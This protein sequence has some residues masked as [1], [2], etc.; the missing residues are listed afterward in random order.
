MHRSLIFSS[1]FV[2]FQIACAEGNP[3]TNFNCGDGVIQE[4]EECEPPNQG[5]CGEYC[6]RDTSK[7]GDGLCESPET[8]AN[9]A[10]DCENSSNCGNG[11]RDMGED[12]DGTD[13]NEAT[14]ES[15]G[16]GAG[17]LTC[18]NTCKFDISGC[19]SPEYC[20]N[21]IVDGTEECDTMDLNDNDC[22]TLGYS[23][24]TLRC[25][26]SCTYNTEE[27]IDA[28]CGNNTA[29]GSED[30]DGT[31]LN[32]GTCSTAGT[33]NNGAL[34]CNN[35]CTY[36]DS[37]CG[38]CPNNILEGDEEC[39]GTDLGT[40][41]CQSVGFTGGSLSCNANCTL[42]T[43]S[44]TSCGNGTIEGTEECDQS[45]LGGATCASLGYQGGT[46][47]CGATCTFNES[48]CYNVVCGDGA[49]TGSE[50]CDGSN[51]GG[52][53]C[54]SLGYVGGNLTC[55]TGCAYNVAGCTMCGDGNQDSGE[56]CDGSDLNGQSCASQGF[57]AGTLSCNSNCTFNYGACSTFTCGNNVADGSDDCDGPDLD[58]QT[59][60]SLGFTGGT[61]ACS[62]GCT[63]NTTGCY[64]CGDGLINGTEQCDG[65]NLGGATCTSQGFTGGNLY[66]NS[67]CT[68]N[69]SSCTICGDGTISSGEECDDGNTT[70]NDGCDNT[71]QVENNFY[72]PVRLVGGEGTNE[73]RLEVNF[74]GNWEQVCDD[75]SSAYTQNLANLV[76]TQLGFT[77]TGHVFSYAHSNS[78]NDVFLM[79]SVACTG[80]ETNLAQCPFDGWWKEDCWSS[81]TVGIRCIPGEG[82]VRLVNGESGMVGKME[83]Y[84]SGTWGDI[85]DDYLENGGREYGTRVFCNQM[86]YKFGDFL[87]N[88]YT[89]TGTFHLDDVQCVGSELRISDCSHLAWGSHNCGA[90]EAGG[91]RCEVWQEGDIRIVG[92]PARNQGRIEVLHNNVWGTICDDGLNY[93]AAGGPLFASVACGELGFTS[94]G[95]VG[96]Y[97][98]AYQG[99]DPIWLD[100]VSCTG[101]ETSVTDCPASAWGS[102]NCSHPED[103]VLTCNP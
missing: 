25:N 87:D 61:L 69:T 60:A 65:S 58:G 56:Q 13:L 12:C 47:A 31:D 81:E 93:G 101:T 72:L 7:C 52:A 34:K 6:V 16:L 90:S 26:G 66:C 15:Q 32:G 43:A 28:N 5:A 2:L 98:S 83:I 29:E 44:C 103:T 19:E 88:V 48:E 51:L 95:S 50:Q 67:G 45:S 86:G 96:D 73:G 53:S 1:L 11:V 17:T 100:E 97:P 33:F 54:T 74:E 46:L 62:A 35:N 20:G 102:H 9:C 39:D 4:G 82:D 24:G 99:T 63:F 22:V 55:T 84:H 71:C 78:G 85:C 57:D 80:T 79:D 27:C 49:I 42:N 8:Q 23:G 10:A 40:K 75:V 70:R 18:D 89:G 77:G 41:T 68:F 30:C 76:C 38:Y 3:S 91:A 14:C 94:A 21:N 92:G 64:R 36:D 59:C 37:G